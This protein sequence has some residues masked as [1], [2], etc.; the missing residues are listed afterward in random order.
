[1]KKSLVGALGGMTLGVLMMCV[2]LGVAGCRDTGTQVGSQNSGS[3]SETVTET[4][5]ETVIY[6]EPPTEVDIPT[7]LP[8]EDMTEVPT[9]PEVPTE[10][11]KPSGSGSQGGSGTQ[12]TPQ[13]PVDLPYYIMINRAANCITIYSK[14]ANGYYTVPF[15]SMICSVGLNDGTSNNATPLG[16]FKISDKYVWRKLFGSVDVWGHYSVRVVGHILFHSVPY[17]CTGQQKDT[18]KTLWEGQYNKLGQP[19]SQGCIRLSVA[20]SKWIYDNCPPGTLVTIYD[21]AANPGPIGRPEAIKIPDNSPLRG[22]DP[23]D[24]DPLNPW[25][26]GSVTIDA[27]TVKNLT[28][29]RGGDLDIVT[30][31]KATDID[32]LPLEVKVIT[33]L[34]INKAGTYKVTYVATGVTGAMATAEAT[35]TVKDTILPTLTVKDSAVKVEDGDKKADILKEIY[36]VLT[37]KDKDAKGK[38]ETLDSTSL[39]VDMK[40]LETAMK[41]KEAGTYECKVYAKDAAGNKSKEVTVKVTYERKDIEK[42]VI[43][44]VEKNPTVNV[45]LTN[46]EDETDRLNKINEVA[47]PVLGTHFTVSDDMSAED[48]ISVNVSEYKGKTEAGTYEVVYTITAKDE[49]KKSAAVQI[50]VK[51]TI[52]DE[53]PSEEPESGEIESGS[54]SSEDTSSQEN[55]NSQP[56][57]DGTSQNI[58]TQEP[59]E[60][61]ELEP[62]A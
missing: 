21:D 59:A 45:D 54:G 10:S 35:V 13:K 42:P 34:D 24:P 29:E 41:N 30:H 11:E 22:W 17:T 56:E 12:T 44:V 18:I 49:A 20:D 4:E 1:M 62:A 48:K 43:T 25:N 37:A 47:A 40:A 50:T 5:S 53:T 2:A 6:T 57:Q 55:P 39:V 9:E 16:T 8:T 38:E 28:V 60:S 31:V 52:I 36:T 26:K 3:Q 61:Q 33:E 51:V 23:T 7:E 27:T 46:I 14:D 15:K 19:A 58:D 32:T